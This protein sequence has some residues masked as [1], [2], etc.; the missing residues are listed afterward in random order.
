MIPQNDVTLT[1]E[2][3]LEQIERLIDA[4]EDNDDVM[5]VWHNWEE[6]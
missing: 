1:E 4:L 5:E 2:K 3:P 6:A